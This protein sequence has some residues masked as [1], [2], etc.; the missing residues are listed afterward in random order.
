MSLIDPV[1]WLLLLTLLFAMLALVLT[2]SAFFENTSD[3]EF[4]T[5][6]RSLAPWMTALVASGASISGWIA[7]GFPQAIADQGFGF[8]VLALAGV[9]IALTGV[10]FLKPQWAIGYRHR[11]TSQG[12]MLNGY[13]GGNALGVLSALIAILIAVGFAGIQLRAVSKLFADISGNGDLFNLYVWGI[14]A[15]VAIYLIIGGMRAAGYIGVLQSAL[16]GL[17]LTALGVIILLHNGGMVAVGQQL[18]TLAQDPGLLSNDL[19]RVAGVIQFTSGHGIDAPIAGQWTAVMIFSSSLGL[20]GLQASPMITQLILSTRSPKGFAAGQTW[21]LAGFFGALV[22]FSV[23]LVGSVGFGAE[24]PI[25][26]RLLSS[27]AMGSPWFTAIIAL[28]MLAAVQI[29]VGLSVVTAAHVIVADVYKPYFHKG[30]TEKLQLSLSRIAIGLILLVAS[31]LA[32]LGPYVLSALSSIALAAA[33][34]LWPAL[35]GLCW[36]KFITRQA[37]LVGLAIGLAA[38]VTTDIIGISILSFL[39]LDLPWGRWPWTIH[40]AGWGIF[41]NLLAVLVISAI[42]R[43]RGHSASAPQI[44]RFL[45]GYMQPRYS[46]RALRPAA[47]SATLAWLF[48]AIGPGVVLGNIAFGA[49]DAGYEAWAVGMPSLWAWTILFWVL[50]V[51]LIWFLSYKM[52]LASDSG[53]EITVLEP[54]YATPHRDTSIQKEELLRLTWVLA[55]SAAIITATAWT[56]G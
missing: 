39:G 49:P 51:F 12:Q 4:F 47:W 20:L 53:R 10:L 35:L 13:F 40:S 31:L 41:F 56:F 46:N 16:I 54:P 3:R 48:L 6:G 43:G 18:A 32:V 24:G 23:V 1:L 50:G 15:F 33:L 38:V 37:V 26:S 17:S 2:R 45:R 5:A 8:A 29:I 11:F 27:I 7:L 28:G 55:G 22:V 36:F 34:Q 44:R 21:V 30:L 19:Y 14:S 52:E 9:V 25:L 42:S